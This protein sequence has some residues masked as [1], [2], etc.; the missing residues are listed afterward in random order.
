MRIGQGDIEYGRAIAQL[1]RC[2]YD[3]ALTVDIRDIPDSP[4][5]IEPEVRKLKYLLESLV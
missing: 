5:P 4:F 3:R 2:R 1:D